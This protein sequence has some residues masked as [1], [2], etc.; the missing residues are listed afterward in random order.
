MKQIKAIM[1]Q[2]YHNL[3]K[4]MKTDSV[5]YPSVSN[6]LFKRMQCLLSKHVNVG[7]LWLNINFTVILMNWINDPRNKSTI[8]DV[9]ERKKYPKA[10]HKC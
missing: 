10:K 4:S 9:T 7:F 6:T 2:I 3:K 8:L 1:W 5:T